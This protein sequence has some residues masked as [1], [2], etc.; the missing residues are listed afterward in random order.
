[1]VYNSVSGLNLSI[2]DFQY[3]TFVI[4]IIDHADL[5]G[6]NL[7]EVLDWGFVNAFNK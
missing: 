4:A 2:I 6:A 3:V 7:Q 5:N 1:M